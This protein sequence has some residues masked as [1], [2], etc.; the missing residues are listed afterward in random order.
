MKKL[1]SVFSLALLTS[2]CAIS[3]NMPDNRFE[4]AEVGAQKTVKLAGGIGGAKD[5]ELTSDYSQTWVSMDSPRITHEAF[6]AGGFAYSFIDNLNIGIKY[7]QDTGLVISSKVQAVGKK[8]EKGFQLAGMVHVGGGSEEKDENHSTPTK[9]EMSN[10]F[11]GGDLIFGYRFSKNFSAYS[12]VFYDKASYKITQTRG[13]DT[14]KY[15]GDSKNTGGNVGL[16]YDFSEQAC[17][18]I[19]FARAKAQSGG[20]RLTTSSFGASMNIFVF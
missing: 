2:S 6:V 19:E 10:S 7:V 20:S 14:R 9:I 3:Y 16:S 5:I 18:M 12:S 15:D 13:S 8:G 1:V 17:L 11:V 4:T